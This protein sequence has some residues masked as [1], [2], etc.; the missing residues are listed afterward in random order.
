MTRATQ[1]LSIPPLW[2]VHKSVYSNEAFDE[3]IPRLLGKVWLFVAHE[4]DFPEVGSFMAPTVAGDPI[5]LSK[6]EDGVIRAF[7]N[8]C[9]H[10]G[11]IVASQDEGTARGFL[12]PY[13]N[14]SYKLDGSL[15]ALP[16]PEAYECVGFRKEDFGLVPVRAENFCGL[17]FVCLDDDAPSL[18]SF[19]GAELTG[20]MRRTVGA[21]KYEVYRK[22]VFDVKANWKMLSENWR[23]G[24]HVPNVHPQLAKGMPPQRYKLVDNGHCIQYITYGRG[25]V[26]DEVWSES[27]KCTL[28]GLEPLTGFHFHLFPG[29]VVQ[30]LNNQLQILSQRAVDAANT[31]WERRALGVAGDSPEERETRK[32]CWTAWS[33]NQVA[34]DIVVL[35]LQQRGIMSR[36]MPVS[37]LA[38]G[39]DASEGIR[40]DDNRLRQF[41]ASWRQYMGASANSW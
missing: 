3:E 36:G 18:E 25:F 11:A 33:S 20:L 19:L 41:W 22:D 31:V 29:L 37:I 34:Q 4:S 32:T 17:V 9:R 8:T 13:H 15:R 2:T 5:L 35:E 30:P 27:Q 10:R 6:A 39:E 12:C 7:Y 1:M 40:G 28:P 26:S 24:Y 14:W 23:D 16:Q 21:A 38:R